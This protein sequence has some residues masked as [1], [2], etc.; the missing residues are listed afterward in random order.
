[1][2]KI[3]KALLFLLGGFMVLMFLLGALAGAFE[4]D[5]KVAQPSETV[6]ASEATETT[7]ETPVEEVKQSVIGDKLQVGDVVFTVN[8]RSRATNAG[9]EYG[10]NSK[11][12]FLIL[13]VSVENLGNEAITVDS[14]YFK[15]LSNG[16]TFEADSSAGIYANED[17]D[18]F[19]ESI[20]PD[21]TMT[22]KVVF[23]I[24]TAMHEEEL[25]VQVQTG[26]FG[27]ETGEI[28]LR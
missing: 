19:Y 5:E 26:M 2:K 22:G 20:N 16:K 21:L 10:V 24:S 25:V 7:I 28:A 6:V 15:L 11:G 14:S 13:D 3:G 18:F 9:G 27:T 17:A 23:D 4:N 8:E 12:E 1:M